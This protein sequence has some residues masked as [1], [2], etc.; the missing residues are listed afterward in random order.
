VSPEQSP[1]DKELMLLLRDRIFELREENKEL[2]KS[3]D[4]A[5]KASEQEAETKRLKCLLQE[6]KELARSL[7]QATQKASVQEVEIKRLKCLL[8]K[9]I[10]KTRN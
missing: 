7:D 8:Q 5:Q 2:A 10:A 6:N 3:L 9:N 1:F 4:Q